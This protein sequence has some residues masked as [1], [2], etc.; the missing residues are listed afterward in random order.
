MT[1]PAGPV[2]ADQ[3]MLRARSVTGSGASYTP[4]ACAAFVAP[5]AH[6]ENVRSAFAFAG[7]AAIECDQCRLP[8]AVV[9]TCSSQHLRVSDHAPPGAAPPGPAPTPPRPDYTERASGVA[10]SRIPGQRLMRLL[11]CSSPNP[12]AVR[13]SYSLCSSQPGL[14]GSSSAKVMSDSRSR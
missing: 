8:L 2:R 10:V 9:A 3:T 1:T 7:V 4:P 5:A 6:Q 12:I 14:A 11:I 13:S